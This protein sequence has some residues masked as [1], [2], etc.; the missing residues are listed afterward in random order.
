MMQN[1]PLQN[2]LYWIRIIGTYLFEIVKLANFTY[3]TL[4]TFICI[5]PLTVLT[6]CIEFIF[7]IFVDVLCSVS[8]QSTSSLIKTRLWQ[9]HL[10]Y[11]HRSVIRPCWHHVHVCATDTTALIHLSDGLQ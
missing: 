10:V 7:F 8:L 3:M 6:K 2:N 9:V 5:S 1:D 11:S 4:H